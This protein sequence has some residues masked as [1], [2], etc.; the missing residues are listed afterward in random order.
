LI[1]L[2]LNKKISMKSLENFGQKGKIK[3]RSVSAFWIGFISVSVGVALQL[4]MYINAENMGYQ[5]VGMPMT[6]SMNWGMILEVLGLLITLYSLLPPSKIQTQNDYHLKVK[7]LDDAP[8]NR[9]H[10]GLL[11]V[12]AIA[13]TIDVMKPTILSFV[14][15][16][17]ARE[18]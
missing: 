12:M 18:Y 3:F 17:M 11:F 14:V 16:G 5:L 2:I 13:I 10:I 6:T 1:P 15:P 8:I 9:T 4:P 7:A